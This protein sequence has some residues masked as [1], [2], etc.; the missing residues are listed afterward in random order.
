M[1]LA[2]GLAGRKQRAADGVCAV[3]AVASARELANSAAPS[4]GCGARAHFARHPAA[5]PRARLRGGPWLV[6]GEQFQPVPAE[7]GAEPADR[8][9]E[10]DAR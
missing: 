8:G 10:P 6:A 5:R 1:L 9:A 4:P 7:R 2:A 3:S